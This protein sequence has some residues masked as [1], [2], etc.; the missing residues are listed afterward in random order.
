MGGCAV[1]AVTQLRAGAAWLFYG[2]MKYVL[3]SAGY[4]R[5]STMSTTGAG[6]GPAESSLDD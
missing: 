1:L 3:R 5:D 6:G 2:T 4:L